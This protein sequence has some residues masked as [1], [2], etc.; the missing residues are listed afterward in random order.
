M[1]YTIFHRSVSCR[2]V[3]EWSH[4][5]AG[6]DERG[7]VILC[8]HIHAFCVIYIQHAAAA[9]AAATATAAAATTAAA[10]YEVDN[11]HN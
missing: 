5:A 4:V 7:G 3:I 1:V 2:F 9:A 10:T 6:A 8:A 11:N